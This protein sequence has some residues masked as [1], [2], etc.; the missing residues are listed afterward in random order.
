M[1]LELEQKK[2]DYF[3]VGK[4]AK[5]FDRDFPQYGLGH[6][7]VWTRNRYHK[8]SHGCYVF[9]KWRV[10]HSLHWAEKKKTDANKLWNFSFKRR[11]KQRK[12]IPSSST[13]DSFLTNYSLGIV[14]CFWYGLQ[15]LYIDDFI[16]YCYYRYTIQRLIRKELVMIQLLLMLLQ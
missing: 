8:L 9:T 14:Q 12:N 3:W 10:F 16:M 4:K 6:P 5:K 2:N 1:V 13:S 7:D 15:N 11:K